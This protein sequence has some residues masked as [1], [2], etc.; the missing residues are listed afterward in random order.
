M[1]RSEL[2]NLWRYTHPVLTSDQHVGAIKFTDFVLF[3]DIVTKWHG[4]KNEKLGQNSDVAKRPE[5]EKEELA[6]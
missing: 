2:T 5:K 1:V 3:F 6:R 4:Y